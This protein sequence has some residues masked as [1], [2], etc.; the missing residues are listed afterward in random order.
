MKA[1][2]ANWFEQE[3]TEKAFYHGWHGGHGWGVFLTTKNTARAAATKT[4]P[5]E[6]LA[7]RRRG[8][9]KDEEETEK[10]ELKTPFSPLPRVKPYAPHL[11]DT[12]PKPEHA[13]EK[14]AVAPYWRSLGAVVLAT[15][16]TS[17]PC[18]SAGAD[19]GKP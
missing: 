16:V 11:M 15:T 17:M 5:R 7:Q 4:V 9:E 14:L 12:T 19:E 8:A 1:G 6:R 10:T 18:Q 3:Q 2:D 13:G